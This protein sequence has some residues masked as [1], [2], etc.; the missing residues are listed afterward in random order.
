M[1]STAPRADC[2]TNESL[3]NT[4]AA[5]TCLPQLSTKASQLGQ[6]T[7]VCDNLIDTCNCQTKRILTVRP[8]RPCNLSSPCDVVHPFSQMIAK[9]LASSS[10]VPT[11]LQLVGIFFVSQGEIQIPLWFVIRAFLK[12]HYGSNVG[13][14]LNAL[15]YLRIERTIDNN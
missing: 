8:E 7:G 11:C 2:A 13:D 14:I 9:H 15:S 12:I 6:D 5:I 4:G 3:I 1:T 10:R